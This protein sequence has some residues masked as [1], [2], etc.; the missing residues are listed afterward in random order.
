[1]EKVQRSPVSDDLMIA[2]KL[3]C[4]TAVGISELLLSRWD[5]KEIHFY[6]S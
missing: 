3:A 6:P 4:Y 2:I 1:L 5:T